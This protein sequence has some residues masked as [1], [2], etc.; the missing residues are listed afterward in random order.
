MLENIAIAGL[1]EESG[2]P[3]GD[4]SAEVTGGMGQESTAQDKES[5]CRVT[6]RKYCLWCGRYGV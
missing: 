4:R 6:V 3:N 2:S 1:L 5:C